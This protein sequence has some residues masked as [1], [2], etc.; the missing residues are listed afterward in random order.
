MFSSS[1][2]FMTW[3]WASRI[4]SYLYPLVF[5]G[6]YKVLA[7]LG[8]DTVELLVSS[9]NIQPLEATFVPNLFVG[10]WTQNTP[11]AADR[12][13][14]LSVLCV[15]WQEEMVFIPLTYIVFLVLRGIK[16]F[17]QHFGSIIDYHCPQHVPLAF[18]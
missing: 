17:D 3:E 14:R 9:G 10:Y 7:L 13:L 12:L 11:S 8:Y 16:D 18:R 2:G 4:R 6:F 15:D 5:A 1:Y